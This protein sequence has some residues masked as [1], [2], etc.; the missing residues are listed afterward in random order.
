[1]SEYTKNIKVNV[2]ISRGDSKVRTST[3]LNFALCDFYFGNVLNGKKQRELM[4]K[5]MNKYRDWLVLTVQAWVKEQA[6]QEQQRLEFT[7][8]E[9]IYDSGYKRGMGSDDGQSSLI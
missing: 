4:Q 2:V 9:K 7:L 1:M 6:H 3:T 8:L 5:G